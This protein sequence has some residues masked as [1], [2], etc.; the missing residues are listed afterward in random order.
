[1]CVCVRYIY[2]IGNTPTQKQH[3]GMKNTKNREFIRI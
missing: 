2:L 3:V 1:M